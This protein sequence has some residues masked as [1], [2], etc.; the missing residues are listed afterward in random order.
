MFKKLFSNKET[1][2]IITAIIIV[3]ALLLV[4]FF[5]A[6]QKSNLKQ[7]AEISEPSKPPG[8]LVAQKSAGESG[9]LAQGKQ[10]Y[11]VMGGGPKSPQIVEVSFDPL[12]VKVGNE[13][14][15]TVKL[16][17]ADTD[18]ITGDTGVFITYLTDNGSSSL[19]LKLRR[20]DDPPIEM[21]WQGTWIPED[22]HDLLYG[23]II[24]AISTSGEE[25][26]ELMFR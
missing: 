9:I 7:E 11:S 23:A 8:K 4:I 12:D 13:Q 22:T 15:V 17:D 16:Q 20:V 6:N 19:N 14:I 26:V 21:T 1:R 5:L 3:L 25:E 24:K 2:K 18:I 10:T